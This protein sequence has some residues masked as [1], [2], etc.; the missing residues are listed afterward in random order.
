MSLDIT[1]ALL[2]NEVFVEDDDEKGGVDV[3]LAMK[4]LPC[5]CDL[6]YTCSIKKTIECKLKRRNWHRRKRLFAMSER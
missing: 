3:V 5:Y 4:L 2:A 1:V 6:L